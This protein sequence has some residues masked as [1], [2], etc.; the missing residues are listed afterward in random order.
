MV[1]STI[2]VWMLRNLS[3]MEAL[4]GRWRV[5]EFSASEYFESKVCFI[6]LGRVEFLKVEWQG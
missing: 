1:S 6:G 3:L 4:G 2:V 5:D